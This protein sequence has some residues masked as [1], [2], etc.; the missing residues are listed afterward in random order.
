MRS[1]YSGLRVLLKTKSHK[2]FV[3][4]RQPNVTLTLIYEFTTDG[5]VNVPSHYSSGYLKRLKILQ[6]LL[7][8]EETLLGE[9]FL[10][11]HVW[12]KCRTV[13]DCVVEASALNQIQ[14]CYVYTKE[15]SR[16]C[17]LDFK[18]TTATHCNYESRV[19]HALK[20]LSRNQRIE[21]FS[22]CM[23]EVASSTHFTEFRGKLR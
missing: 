4:K 16:F 7:L 5:I 21:T 17:T 14:R 19:C 11:L 8:V 1:R 9:I 3:N 10:I 20:Q 15:L 22:W 2:L 23:E 12:N 18:S 13:E 6:C